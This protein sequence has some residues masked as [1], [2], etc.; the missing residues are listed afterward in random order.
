MSTADRRIYKPAPQGRVLI[1]GAGGFLGRYFCAHFLSLGYKVGGID[2][3][4]YGIT[5][6]ESGLQWWTMNLP[7]PELELVVHRFQPDLIIHSAGCARVPESMSD[8]LQDFRCNVD[9]TICVFDSVRKHAPDCRVL[10]LSSAAVYG[11]P[12]RLPIREDDDIRPLSPYGYH[13]RMAE[14]VAG[15]YAQVYDIKSVILRI[16]SAY[17]EGLRRQVIHDLCRKLTDSG[18]DITVYGTGEETR[19]FIH[20]EDIARASSLLH[21]AD[22][23]G[24]Y[25]VASGTETSIADLVSQLASILNPEAAVRYTGTVRPGDP[26]NWKADV[27]KIQLLGFQP[28]LDL[29]DGLRRYAAWFMN[30]HEAVA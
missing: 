22:A 9:P 18:P 5:G 19:D 29:N 16:F 27:R 21:E 14:L 10:V 26:L 28:T 1:T 23:I 17:G 8:P 2:K 11:S 3:E 13:K 24:T 6:R 25:N 7:D 30:Q 12:V 4:P 15:E 20:A